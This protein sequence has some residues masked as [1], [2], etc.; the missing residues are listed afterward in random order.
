LFRGGGRRGGPG[1][2]VQNRGGRRLFGGG[3]TALPRPQVG[4]GL[5]F[6][7]AGSA[8]GLSGMGV[9]AVGE[10]RAGGTR[11]H[12]PTGY[13][14]SEALGNRGPGI[15]EH[16]G[17]EFHFGRSLQGIIRQSCFCFPILP[18]APKNRGLTRGG[19]KKQVCVGWAAPAFGVGK[20]NN[21][22]DKTRGPLGGTGMGPMGGRN[23][24]P[25]WGGGGG[26]GAVIFGRGA[27][28]NRAQRRKFFPLKGAGPTGLLFVETKGRGGG[29]V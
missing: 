18:G 8:K 20:K 12:F 28:P 3:G 16:A 29:L 24:K 14:P 13:G 11:T 6:F 22:P 23:P 5:R 4:G 7:P 10:T 25:G 19:K 27:F 15:F 1:S 26:R 9:P 21:V 2:G 17:G